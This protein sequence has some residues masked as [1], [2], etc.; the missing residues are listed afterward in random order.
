MSFVAAG[1]VPPFLT[2][3]L[4]VLDTFGVQLAHLSPI[5]V[6]T[7]AIFAHFCEIFVGVPPLVT[8][9][10]HFFVLRA[11]G[12]RNGSDEVEVV[13]PHDR[14]TLPQTPTEP[15][16]QN[17]VEC[18]MVQR[19]HTKV[20]AQRREN[21]TVR[22][23]PISAANGTSLKERLK[24]A[25]DELDTILS[26]RTNVKLMMWDI[27]Q[28]A[29]DTVEAAEL[30]LVFMG[31]QSLETEM[32]G[33]IALGFGEI[34]RR[35]EALPAAVQ[36][37]VTREGRALVQGVAEH[38]LAWYRSQDPAFQL[39]PARQGVV[40]AEEAAAREA[41]R[42]IATEVAECFVRESGLSSDACSPPEPVNS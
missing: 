5:S 9:F 14:L 17:V 29:R 2:F 1:L 41:L 27:L 19:A 31:D 22:G 4:Q 40:E 15:H 8:L 34:A 20:A 13:G 11:A 26:E 37:L 7:L 24:N 10:R 32:I 36:E 12:K 23:I 16:S 33:H 25:E 39:E 38:I 21:P 18:W 35:L 6:V 3:F 30:G 28:Q 42:D